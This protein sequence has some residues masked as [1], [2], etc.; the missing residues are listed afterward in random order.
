MKTKLDYPDEA[1]V[2]F[3]QSPPHLEYFDEL[4]WNEVPLEERLEIAR[5]MLL[6]EKIEHSFDY[7]GDGVSSCCRCGLLTG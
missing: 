6:C 2:A 1:V 7:W 4:A 5:K 3:M